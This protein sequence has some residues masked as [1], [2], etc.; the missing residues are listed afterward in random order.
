MEQATPVFIQCEDGFKLQAH[1]YPADE[2]N[3]HVV[4]MPSALAVPQRF[5]RHF[6]MY[7]AS[8]GMTTITFDY[9]GTFQ[10]KPL[11][12]PPFQDSL[13]TWGK[14]DLSAVIEW[15]HGRFAPKRLLMVGHSMGG[16][17]LAFAPNHHRI[18]AVVTITVGS[19]YFGH[20]PRF[21]WALAMLWY[22]FVPSLTRLW[23]YFPGKR[24]RVIGDLPRGVAL[25][26]SRWCR[27][28][29][30]LVDD[31]G[32]PFVKPFSDITCPILSYSFADDSLISESA[33]EALHGFFRNAQSL[34]RRHLHPHDR[35]L[36]KIGHFGFFHPETET[37]GLWL[38]VVSW[39]KQPQVLNT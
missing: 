36:R 28:P 18:D 21:S 2:P 13:E 24:I 31:H 7:L 12:R 37:S 11:P 4:I 15:A 22:I 33:V 26:W 34:E 30:Y 9:R 16:K 38:E 8:Q 29:D 35:G 6:A 14:L 20:H 17:I 27:H 19:G 25:Q 23:G 1:F 32:K 5:Y 10:S 3:G 39:L